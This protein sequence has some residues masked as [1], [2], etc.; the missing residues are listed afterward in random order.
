VTRAWGI[1]VAVFCIIL[2]GLLG[3]ADRRSDLRCEPGLV[4][5]CACPGG[6]EGIQPCAADGSRWLGCQGCGARNAGFGTVAALGPGGGT[7]GAGPTDPGNLIPNAALSVPGPERDAPAGWTFNRWGRSAAKGT[8]LESG[9]VSGGGALRVEVSRHGDGDAKWHFRRV[10][11][12][13]DAWYSYSDFHR[14]DGRSRMVLSCRRGS[15]GVVSYRNIW[16]S[17]ASAAWRREEVRFYLGPAA[18]CEATIF[19]LVDRTG[20]LETSLAALV[21]VEPRPLARPLVSLAFDDGWKSAVTTARAD[22]EERGF[23][24]SYYLVKSFIGDPGGRYA[25]AADLRALLAASRK[26]HEIG[27]HTAYH[28]LLG[29]LSAPLRRQELRENLDWLRG[30]GVTGAGLAYPFGDFDDRVG[31]EA[32]ALHPYARTSFD[33][34]NDAATDRYRITVLPVTAGTETAEILARIDDAVRTSTWLVL[35]FHDVGAPDPADPYRTSTTQFTAV[36]DR[37]AEGDAAVV[38][39][40]AALKEIGEQAAPVR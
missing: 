35:L 40:A 3:C 26:G 23:T 7:G 34:L 33:G 19:H 32:R 13:G 2:A 31:V 15:D 39:V 14:S 28:H 30:L 11:L 29:S 5:S 24:G 9:G 36:L 18:D 27:S 38:T 12:A 4:R 17:E 20:F 37:L 8:W 6:L 1:S 22:L 10:R 16:Q 25:S 21:P